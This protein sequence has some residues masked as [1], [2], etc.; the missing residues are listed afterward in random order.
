MVYTSDQGLTGREGDSSFVF[1]PFT[2]ACPP[3]KIEENIK[4]CKSC[5]FCSRLFAFTALFLIMFTIDIT[6]DANY[7]SLTNQ[8]L[9]LVTVLQFSL[10]MFNRLNFQRTINKHPICTYATG[11]KILRCKAKSHAFKIWKPDIL[12]AF[13]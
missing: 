1:L 4:Q 8:S 11:L 7:T 6:K 3:S 13:A 5:K 9:R 2:S 12:R 10:K